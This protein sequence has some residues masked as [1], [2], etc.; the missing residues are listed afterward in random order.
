V[1]NQI[2]Y[3]VNYRDNY[4][5]TRITAIEAVPL[6]YR[7]NFK[8]WISAGIGAL[9][10]AEISRKTTDY[11]RAEIVGPNGVGTQ[12]LQGD[13]GNNNETFA[14]WRG[15]LFADLQLGRVRT[16]PAIGVRL[17]QYV[18]PSY[19]NIMVYASWKF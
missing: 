2:A 10:A 14:S 18:N 19:Q 9:V 16:G 8:S 15:A 3:K 12:L 17:L 11:Q 6:Q 4:R 7:Y 5:S 1:I 13:I